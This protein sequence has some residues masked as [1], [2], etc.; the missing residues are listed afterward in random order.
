[1]TISSTMFAETPACSSELGSRGTIG[2]LGSFVHLKRLS[3]SRICF[4]KSDGGSWFGPGPL[5]F[6]PGALMFVP[7]GDEG[8]E[9]ALVVAEEGFGLLAGFGLVG[10]CDSA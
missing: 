8:V 5:T 3:S 9:G 2:S 1:M 7:D 6:E 4:A 10:W